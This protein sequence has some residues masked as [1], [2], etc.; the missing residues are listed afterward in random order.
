MTGA[1]TAPRC[2]APPGR[3]ISPWCE[4]L[5]AKGADVSNRDDPFSATPMGWASTTG[6]QRGRMA[7]TALRHRPAR[8]RV[9]R[10]AGSAR[11]AASR[12]SRISQHAP[13]RWRDSAGRRRCTRRRGRTVRTSGQD[14]PGVRRRSQHPGGQRTH[15]ARYRGPARRHRRR[16]AARAA[17]RHA[18]N[19]GH[20]DVD[21]SQAEAVREGLEDVLDAY[22]SGAAAA[23]QR[24]QEFINRAV[25][26]SELRKG[27]QTRLQKGDEADIRDLWR[28]RGMLSPAYAASRAGRRSRTASRVRMIDPKAGRD[29]SFTSTSGATRLTCAVR[30]TTR[31]G[32]PSSR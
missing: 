18:T 27:V 23:L 32:T 30:R 20:Q 11:G 19:R 24:V 5:V 13:G 22:Q 8:R 21:A 29:R 9:L 31:S 17:R 3:A 10:S 15:A 16:G 26:L 14:P 2:T 25:T 7:S 12:R 28:K 1:T 4:R 6:S